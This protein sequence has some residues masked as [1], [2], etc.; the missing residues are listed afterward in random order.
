[1][2]AISGDR[3]PAAADGVRRVQLPGRA[4]ER[5]ACGLDRTT[6]RRAPRQLTTEYGGSSS[7]IVHRIGRPPS[8]RCAVHRLQMGR[9]TASR[10]RHAWTGLAAACLC[11]FIAA[12]SVTASVLHQ[13]L[14]PEGCPAPAASTT[15]NTAGIARGEVSIDAVT[16]LLPAPLHTPLRTFIVYYPLQAFGGCF[17][18]RTDK[19]QWINIQPIE[20]TRCS[21]RI[22]QRSAITGQQEEVIKQGYTSV[23][24]SAAADQSTSGEADAVFRRLAGWISAVDIAREDRVAEWS[25]AHATP[26][27]AYVSTPLSAITW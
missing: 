18:W 17:Q 5:A 7:A 26:A 10:S 12:V 4:G 6:S 16:V 21:E 11:A 13:S 8:S 3:A 22:I 24:V 25:V 23:Y 19:P 1:M 15:A 14:P 2:A 27:F 20:Q 9:S